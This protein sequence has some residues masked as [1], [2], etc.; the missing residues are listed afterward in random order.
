MADT[1]SVMLGVNESN[2]NFIDWRF[3]NPKNVI[4][5]AVQINDIKLM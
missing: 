2:T 4:T 5:L 3:V 1:A